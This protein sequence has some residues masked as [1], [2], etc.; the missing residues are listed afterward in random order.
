MKKKRMLFFACCLLS[1]ALPAQTPARESLFADAYT[2]DARKCGKLNLC[3]DNISFFNNLETGGDVQKGYTL[4]GFRIYP[5]LTYYPASMIKLEA[6]V[7]LLRY[8]GADKYPNYVYLDIAEWKAPDYQAGF[9]LQPFFRAQIQPVPQLNIVLG[10]IYGGSNHGLIEPLYNP[11]LNLTADPE[12]GAQIIYNSRIAHLDAWVN[13]E[14]FI[15]RNEMN[16]EVMTTGVSAGLHITNPQSFFYLGIPVQVL[17][18]H[19]GGEIDISTKGVIS[20]INGATGLQFGFN[21]N[22]SGFKYLGLSLMGAGYKNLHSEKPLLFEQGWAACSKLNIRFGDF[23]LKA[24]FWRSGNFINLFGSPVFGN[25]STSKENWNFPRITVFNP[26]IQ[27][28]RK[29][30]AGLYLGAN[31]ECFIAPGFT[32]YQEQDPIK[33][34]KYFGTSAGLFLRINPSIVL[35][36]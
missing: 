31:F 23:D 5:R 27:Y 3:I 21:F 15:F 33:T 35:K 6:G 7:S 9:H 11:E 30:G 20:L 26:G 16:S 14:N 17:A 34:E 12:M 10:H 13:W 8:W 32:M 24:I 36:K 4:P 29:F 25:V 2:I 22:K 28:E 18:N 19:H 1:Q